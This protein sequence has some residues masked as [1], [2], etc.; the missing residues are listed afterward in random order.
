MASNAADKRKRTDLLHRGVRLAIQ[1]MFFILAPSVFSAAFNGVKYIFT[2]LGVAAPIEATSFLV[3]LVGVLAFTILFG[4][5][6]CG[7]ACAF[8]TL[9]DV[10]FG[11][12]DFLRSKTPI[13]R[14]EFPDKLVRALSL[15]KFAILIGICAACFFGVWAVVS[16]YSPW[17]AF[18]AF[19]SGSLEGVQ[20]AAFVTLGL[21]I[22]GMILRE[23]FFC[24]FLCPLG[25]IFS[26]MPVLGCSEF[27]RTPSLCPANCGR[28]KKTCPVDIWP[29]GGT[30]V[31]GECISCGRCADV[32]PIGN[33]NLVAI[34]KPQAVAAERAD[35]EE[36]AA[37]SIKAKRKTKA[38]WHLL[39]G[40]EV[41]VVLVKAVLLLVLFWVL[42]ATRYLPAFQDV[43]GFLPF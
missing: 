17:V 30:V 10:L 22:V 32:C 20:V 27:T 13:P 4:R 38:N 41:P 26:L 6:F 40:T 8:G 37:K 34:E 1:I 9:G 25:A 18:A 16:G 42:G 15:V 3:L 36:A 14:L 28:C 24:Q 29:D 21:V 35:G 33:I 31:H 11:V 2:Q 39:R 12:F 7:F 5:F 23:R 43:F 19:I